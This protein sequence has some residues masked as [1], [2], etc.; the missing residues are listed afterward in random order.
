[1]QKQA[2][3]GVGIGVIVV[4]LGALAWLGYGES[5][6]YYHTIAELTELARP[7]ACISA[8]ASAEP[9]SREHPPWRGSR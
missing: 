4:A 1:M 8:C 9:L 3:F 6:T 5:K 2:K 7:G